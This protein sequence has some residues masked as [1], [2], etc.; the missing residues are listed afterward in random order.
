MYESICIQVEARTHVQQCKTTWA[1]C[2]FFLVDLTVDNEVA[3]VLPRDDCCVLG[4]T[5]QVSLFSR[6]V[7]AAMFCYGCF[8]FC[9]P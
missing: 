3:Y 4:G 2:R 8:R 5:E 6:P 9:R 1:V 7:G